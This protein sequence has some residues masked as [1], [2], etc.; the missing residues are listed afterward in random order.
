[1]SFQAF[2]LVQNGI[3]NILIKQQETASSH[4]TDHHL[5]GQYCCSNWHLDV[6]MKLHEALLK[7]WA[8]T[9][10]SQQKFKSIILPLMKRSKSSYSVMPMRAGICMV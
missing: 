2:P 3:L 5:E 1:M 4:D 8:V 6:V 7:K 9:G 10:N